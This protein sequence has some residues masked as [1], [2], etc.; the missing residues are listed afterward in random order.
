MN[1]PALRA[2]LTQIRDSAIDALSAMDAT[3]AA[4]AAAPA[5]PRAPLAVDNPDVREWSDAVAATT[6]RAW[7][8]ATRDGISSVVGPWDALA[9]Y[10]NRPETSDAEAETV[11]R[12]RRRLADGFLADEP[13]GT[14]CPRVIAAELAAQA[15]A[16][17]PQG[18]LSGEKA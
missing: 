13:Y 15:A 18:F 16:G 7:Q 12:S 11:R 9:L 5:G 4:P 8:K 2:A 14:E 6:L 1:E 3:T 10:A 17:N